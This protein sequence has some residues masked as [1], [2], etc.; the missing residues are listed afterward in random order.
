MSAVSDL[1]D[2]WDTHAD[3][4]FERAFDGGASPW[5]AM[6]RHDAAIAQRHARELR[7]AL[8]ADAPKQP[9]TLW[10]AIVAGVTDA[11]R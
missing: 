2:R 6:L 8:E 4:L 9:R 3:R 11:L 10:Q 1:A 5:A 7:A